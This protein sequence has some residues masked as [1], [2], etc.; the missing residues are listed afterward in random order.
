VSSS[1]YVI[2]ALHDT[3]N[4]KLA[5]VRLVSSVTNPLYLLNIIFLALC[6]ELF[7][8]LKWGQNRKNIVLHSFCKQFCRTCLLYRTPRC[9]PRA[10]KRVRQNGV[11]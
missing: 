8:N 11:L 3:L 1:C 2:T 4:S 9:A 10:L 5:I 6:L 7:K